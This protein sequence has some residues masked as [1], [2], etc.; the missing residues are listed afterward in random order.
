M[1]RLSDLSDAERDHIMAKELPSFAA[2]PWV[3][4]PPR[5]ERRVAIITTAGLHRLVT[6]LRGQ[7]GNF[8]VATVQQPSLRCGLAGHGQGLEPAGLGDRIGQSQG[9]GVGYL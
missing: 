8:R 7:S 4:G 5:A 9:K 1:V 3:E 2:R 6:H